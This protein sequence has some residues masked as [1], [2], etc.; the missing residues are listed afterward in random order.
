[1]S[2]NLPKVQLSLYLDDELAPP[3]ACTVEAHVQTCAQ[4]REEVTAHR[5]LQTLLRTTLTR[6]EAPARL[7][8]AI[9]QQ[10]PAA[11]SPPRQ[12]QPHRHAAASGPRGS[13]TPRKRPRR[14]ARAMGGAVLA[15][16]ALVVLVLGAKLWFGSPVPGVV[17]EIVDSQIRAQLMQAPYTTID[18]DAG[19]I[20]R[21]FHDKV[22]FSVI[23]PDVAAM[24]YDVLGVRLNYFLDRRVAEIA[25]ASPSH[26]LAFLMFA[27]QD[28]RLET[29]PTVQTANR[30]FYVQKYKGY[31]TVLWQDGE[32]FCSLVSD[33]DLAQLVQ[34]ARRVTGDEIPS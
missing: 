10:L 13:E 17:H 7:W 28:I 24:Q 12:S 23:V 11:P 29:M 6:E 21:W 9:R 5:R 25:Y 2:C 20:R 26:G 15:A 18:A 31:S 3:E 19:A 4:C 1:M 33:L 22:A 16:A 30:V 14:S 34:I 32:F 27:N 8:P